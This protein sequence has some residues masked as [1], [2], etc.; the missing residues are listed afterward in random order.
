M[1]EMRYKN[2]NSNGWTITVLTVFLACQIMSCRHTQS[3]LSKGISEF[4]GDSTAFY[5]FTKP[6]NGYKISIAH[7]ANITMLH[8]E[9]GDSFSCYC[10]IDLLPESI[11]ESTTEADCIFT[12]DSDIPVVKVDTLDDKHIPESDVFFMDVN[13]DGEEEFVQAI[14]GNGW[15]DYTCYDLVNGIYESLSPGVVPAMEQP[16]YDIFSTGIEPMQSGYVAFNHDKKEI[17]VHHG[18][19]CCA[20][21]DTWAKYFEG[22]S[23][24]NQSSIKVVR[25]EYHSFD[26]QS[27]TIETYALQNDTLKMVGVMRRK[28]LFRESIEEDYEHTR[29]GRILFQ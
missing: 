9:R 13:F 15:V 18:S 22:D 17:F 28:Y 5:F 8:F 29:V 20:F 4:W 6:Q 11:K 26:G 10:A 23:L 19:G 7:N 27:E 2:K 21:T 24:G 12:I 1:D 3:N 16:P 25:E 14:R